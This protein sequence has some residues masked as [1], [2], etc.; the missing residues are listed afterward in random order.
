MRPEVPDVSGPTHSDRHAHRHLASDSTSCQ[1]I[2]DSQRRIG[3]IPRVLPTTQHRRQ[4][5][6][7]E[8][9]IGTRPLRFLC[10]RCSPPYKMQYLHITNPPGIPGP[11]LGLPALR[12]AQ[13]SA[14]ATRHVF[15]CCVRRAAGHTPLALLVAP[16]LEDFVLLLRFIQGF[17]PWKI[18]IFPDLQIGRH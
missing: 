5:A 6:E 10:E 13:T 15:S 4:T 9:P 16:L 3:G 17:S 12:P 2:V 14:P 1:T 7:Q 8:E 18:V 11:K